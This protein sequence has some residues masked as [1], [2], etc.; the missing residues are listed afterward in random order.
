MYTIIYIYMADQLDNHK[1]Y[2]VWPLAK[3]QG[4]KRNFIS[5]QVWT[6][7]FQAKRRH[8]SIQL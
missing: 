5:I 4:F 2:D 1:K 7:G 6:Y 8:F 3:F